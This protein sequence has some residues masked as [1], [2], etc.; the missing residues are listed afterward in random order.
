MQIANS[1]T[2]LVFP[3]VVCQVACVF[4]NYSSQ[5]LEGQLLKHTNMMR[6]WQPRYFR[7]DPKQ[8]VL[9]YYIVCLLFVVCYNVCCMLLC[10]VVVQG[11]IC[12][13][14]VAMV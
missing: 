1:L 8:A 9:S 5:E 12:I 3:S 14:C 7:L 10:V 2:L 4:A 13:A 6:G 11:S